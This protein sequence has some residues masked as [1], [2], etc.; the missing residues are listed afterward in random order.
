MAVGIRLVYTQTYY[1][2]NFRIG[3]SFAF[4][5]ETVIYVNRN[6]TILLTT[7]ISNVRMSMIY[8]QVILDN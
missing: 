2:N 6:I 1:I 5:Y 3:I 4:I 7:V 8:V